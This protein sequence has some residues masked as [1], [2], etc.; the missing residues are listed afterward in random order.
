MAKG[1]IGILICCFVCLVSDGTC[2][3]A[4]VLEHLPIDSPATTKLRDNIIIV[5]KSQVGIREAT[6]HNDGKEILKFQQAVGLKKGD[7]YCVAA[8]AWCHDQVD[9]PHPY[10]GYSPDWFKANV[11]YRK[12]EV[13]SEP[14]HSRPGQVGGIYIQSKGRIGHGV[15]IDQETPNHYQVISFNSTLKGSVDEG[16]GVIYTIYRKE[17]INVIADYVGWREYSAGV[18]ALK[19]K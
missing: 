8:I 3:R 1:F 19:K 17:T 11:V 10:S 9:V 7:A 15:L 4:L 16:E 18:K 12:G 13:R 5:A 6:G 14:F 2:Q